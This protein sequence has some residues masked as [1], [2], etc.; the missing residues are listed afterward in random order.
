MA[1]SR[2]FVVARDQDGRRDDGASL[3]RRDPRR[4]RGAQGADLPAPRR[5]RKRASLRQEQAQATATSSRSKCP[6]ASVRGFEYQVSPTEIYQAAS[7]RRGAGRP[8][9][10]ICTSR[11]SAPP[12]RSSSATI[13]R[14]PQDGGVR[15]EPARSARRRAGRARAALEPARRLAASHRGRIRDGARRI[16]ALPRHSG[17]RVSAGGSRR[18]AAARLLSARA[19]RPR[20]T[21]TPKGTNPTRAD[22]AA[23]SHSRASPR[24]STCAACTPFCTSSCRTTASTSPRPSGTPVYAARAEMIEWVGDGGPSGN[25]V[26]IRHAEGLTTGY[27]APLA[28]RPARSRKGKASRRASSSA[29]W[30]HRAFDRR[31]TFTSAPSATACSSIPSR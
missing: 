2:A 28:L 1:R 15:A 30:V 10:S 16:R 18:A 23:R 31:R 26:T 3:V 7:A 9:V 17:R 24:A 5:V 27:C 20:D 22:F 14:R 21:S 25:L 19:T 12:A 8:S 11:R 4:R 13:S 6:R 29:T